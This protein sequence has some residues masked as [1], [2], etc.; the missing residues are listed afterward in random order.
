M[1]VIMTVELAQKM[2]QDYREAIAHV[3]S[4]DVFSDETS[5]NYDDI[6]DCLVSWMSD[7]NIG[8]R[9]VELAEYKY[10]VPLWD[11]D[12]ARQHDADSIGLT[13]DD[14]GSIQLIIEQL[15]YRLNLLENF[16]KEN[17]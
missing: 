2:A 9:I 7:R 1:A 12:W 13:P 11:C 4:I 16:I 10:G 5:E 8:V 14:V 6:M 15:E 3:G 17:Q